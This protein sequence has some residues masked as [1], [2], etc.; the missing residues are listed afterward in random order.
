MEVLNEKF[1]STD[2]LQ[3]AKGF[4]ELISKRLELDTVGEEFDFELPHA[5][6]K[7]N[8]VRIKANFRSCCIL[9]S[10]ITWL[11]VFILSPCVLL[12]ISKRPAI[13]HSETLFARGKLSLHRVAILRQKMGLD[14]HYKTRAL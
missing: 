3:F 1:V 9:W 6:S 8:T 12:Y 5:V 2:L 14:Y 10:V 13:F 11:A 7:P 4:C